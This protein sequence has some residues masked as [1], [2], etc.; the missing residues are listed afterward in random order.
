MEILPSPP[1]QQSPIA[2]PI[3]S[4][5]S[6]CSSE[7]FSHPV[8]RAKKH[9]SEKKHSKNRHKIKYEVEVEN[10]YFEDRTRDRGNCNIESLCSRVRPRYNFKHAYLGFDPY[11]LHSKSDLLVQRYYAFAHNPKKHKKK[12]DTVI[13]RGTTEKT[14]SQNDD[15]EAEF[16]FLPNEEEQRMAQTKEFNEKIADSPH[17][18]DLWLRYVKA[19]DTL[20]S[21]ETYDG[22]EINYAICQKKLSILETALERNPGSK[23]LLREKLFIMGEFYADD[24]FADE[25]E[26]LV[27]KDTGNVM[28]WQALIMATQ[29]S[30]AVCTVSK[31][32]NLYSRCFA[33]LRQWSRTSSRNHDERLLGTSQ[34]LSIAFV[35][36]LLQCLFYLLQFC[37]NV[38]LFR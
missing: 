27:S 34:D 23:E 17:D 14:D 10:V 29:T 21:F 32:M 33:N 28:L 6:D 26:K 25:L 24:E 22:R 36:R 11:Q 31:V 1:R 15:V 37:F 19:Q 20:H 7:E 3:V 16:N 30:V 13:K 18:V 35:S 4:L 2:H 8:K 12:Q 9:N 5:D 38:A